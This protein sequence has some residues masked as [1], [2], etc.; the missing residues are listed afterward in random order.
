[1]IGN[2]DRYARLEVH[3]ADGGQDDDVMGFTRAQVI[4]DC[5]DAY[6]AHLDFLRTV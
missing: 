5:L 2:R 4:H 1:M 3:L 6:E